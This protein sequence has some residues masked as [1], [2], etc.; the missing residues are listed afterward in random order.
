MRW[1]I[2]GRP[3]RSIPPD[4][5]AR[6]EVIAD[7]RD[8]IPIL[9][10]LDQHHATRRGLTMRLPAIRVKFVAGI[11]LTVLLLA[12]P[13]TF[14]RDINPGVVDPNRDAF[15]RSYEEWSV[16]WWQWVFS[17]PANQ[18]DGHPHPLFD[19]TGADCDEGQK[20]KVWFLGGIIVLEGGTGEGIVRD[21]A[22]PKGTALF[23]PIINS[24]A[25]NIPGDYPPAT[26]LKE[27]KLTKLCRDNV[28]DPA[29]LTVEL[30]GQ[31]LQHL[32]R[33]AIKPTLFSYKVPSHGSIDSFFG[34]PFTG[35]VPEPGAVSCGYYIF[36][37]PLSTG[38][39]TLLIAATNSSE[40]F[41]F[42]VTYNLSVG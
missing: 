25:D 22:I 8:A 36:L 35:K 13:A 16:A 6:Q 7:R 24:E 12:S 40:T 28:K 27:S 19:T 42:D 23:F 21:C 1:L 9:V 30:D 26:T 14:A 5:P 10:T 20:G 2:L 37:N 15:G 32:N 11:L 39:H 17:L 3:R 29:A 38:E 4:A 41:K 34:I 18:P 31:P 33:Y